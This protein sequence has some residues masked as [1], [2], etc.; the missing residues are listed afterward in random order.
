MMCNM[1]P[2][3]QLYTTCFDT[4]RET[5]STKI[6]QLKMYKCEM[7]KENGTSGYELWINVTNKRDRKNLKIIN[8]KLTHNLLNIN[9][10]L[11]SSN[12]RFIRFVGANSQNLSLLFEYWSI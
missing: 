4:Q 12:P 1:K 6:N 3:I 2:T 5:N 10:L 7:Y 8:T 11:T 9:L